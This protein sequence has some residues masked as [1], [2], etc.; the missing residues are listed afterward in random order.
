MVQADSAAISAA[1]LYSS[2]NTGDI[3]T[4]AK[5]VTGTYG[6]VDGSNSTTFAL[7]R[8]GRATVPVP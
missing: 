1:T 4:Q 6:F 5:G 8:A 3:T 7:P 2:T